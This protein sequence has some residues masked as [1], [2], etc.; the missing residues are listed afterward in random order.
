MTGMGWIPAW[1]ADQGNPTVTCKPPHL[2]VGHHCTFVPYWSSSS[3]N[4]LRYT[5]FLR[6][7]WS[8][9]KNPTIFVIGIES[10][11]GYGRREWETADWTV[12]VKNNGTLITNP[13]RT[14]IYAFITTKHDISVSQYSLYRKKKPQSTDKYFGGASTTLIL[15]LSRKQAR[16]EK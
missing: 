2:S 15:S 1:V 6:C 14:N 8:F 7:P 16:E 10:F 12:I 5:H 4:S 9:G 13:S 3:R 11:T